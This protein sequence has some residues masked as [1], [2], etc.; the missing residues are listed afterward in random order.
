MINQSQ[1]CFS[2]VLTPVDGVQDELAMARLDVSVH[3]EGRRRCAVMREGQPARGPGRQ[4]GACA[5]GAGGLG[6][7]GARAEGAGV[8]GRNMLNR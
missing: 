4:P 3:A 2:G 1:S 5:F 8:T 7:P 6:R